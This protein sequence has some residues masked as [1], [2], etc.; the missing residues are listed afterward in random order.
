MEKTPVTSHSEVKV[1]VSETIGVIFLGIVVLVLLVAFLRSQQ[2][3]REAVK[4]T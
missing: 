4:N 1:N 2:Q 3:L